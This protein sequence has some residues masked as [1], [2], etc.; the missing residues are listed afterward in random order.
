MENYFNNSTWSM[1]PCIS[2]FIR[3]LGPCRNAVCSG[4]KTQHRISSTP[5]ASVLRRSSFAGNVAGENSL[6][7]PPHLMAL[8]RAHSCTFINSG[9]FP[10]LSSACRNRVS[11][12]EYSEFCRRQAGLAPH[13]RQMMG[14]EFQAREDDAGTLTGGS[15]CF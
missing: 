15:Q 4:S 8:N 7:K 14:C 10:F 6:E 2:V 5:Q 12:F 1:S 11:Q 3:K 9:A 13:G